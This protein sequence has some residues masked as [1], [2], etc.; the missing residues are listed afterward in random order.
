MDR[1]WV[2]F[3]DLPDSMASLSTDTPDPSVLRRTFDR[4][5]LAAADEDADAFDDAARRALHRRT[6]ETPSPRNRPR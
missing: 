4:I 2:A 5:V 1:G 3:R 6:R